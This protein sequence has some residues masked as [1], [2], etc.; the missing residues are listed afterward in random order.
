MMH[1]LKD[2]AWLYESVQLYVSIP[3][4][5]LTLNKKKLQACTVCF[6]LVLRIVSA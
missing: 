1:N 6:E 2:H 3:G 4:M 5:P